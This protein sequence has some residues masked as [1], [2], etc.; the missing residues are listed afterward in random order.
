MLA[1]H[2]V[3]CAGNIKLGDYGLAV[4][5][6]AAKEEAAAAAAASSSFA[7][8]RAARVAMTPP[9][10]QCT[11]CELAMCEA[12]RGGRPPSACRASLRLVSCRRTPSC[13]SPHATDD[14]RL[15]CPDRP[16]DQ[17]TD[18]LPIP[19]CPCRTSRAGLSTG[20]GTFLYRAPE[21]AGVLVTRNSSKRSQFP[22]QEKGD[23]DDG[24]GQLTL[25]EREEREAERCVAVLVNAVI[26]I[27]VVVVVAV[28]L[29]SARPSGGS[30]DWLPHVCVSDWMPNTRLDVRLMSSD[31]CEVK[32]PTARWPVD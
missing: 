27:V 7:A 30:V 10:G 25:T 24:A 18:N 31:S 26:V 14:A 32:H 1:V 11:V 3:G 20:V 22:A 6:A 17:P 21:Q 15:R 28:V 16:T 4:S 8:A 12:A 5:S 23:N 2:F 9:S 19:I 13:T 29:R